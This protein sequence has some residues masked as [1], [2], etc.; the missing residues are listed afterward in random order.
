[1]L[2]LRLVSVLSVVLAEIAEVAKRETL[3][4]ARAESLFP[5]AAGVNLFRCFKSSIAIIFDFRRS[6][7]EIYELQTKKGN[8]KSRPLW[9]ALF[10]DGVQFIIAVWVDLNISRN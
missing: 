10:R 5:A 3:C 9:A 6:V 1:M 8:E 4:F 7:F 2:W